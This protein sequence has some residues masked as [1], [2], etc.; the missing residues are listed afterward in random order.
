MEEKKKGGEREGRETAPTRT[1]LSYGCCSAV[2]SGKSPG[3][4]VDLGRPN[5]F[6]LSSSS[7]SFFRW[8]ANIDRRRKLFRS[9]FHRNDSP[10][11]YRILLE[12]KSTLLPLPNAPFLHGPQSEV[13][14]HESNQWQDVILCTISYNQ[15]L[16]QVEQELV[17]NFNILII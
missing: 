9:H 3:S 16:D 14:S 12:T 8:Q 2:H 4:P 5:F 17:Y 6:F 1:V 11:S 15:L 13:S 10:P 7:S